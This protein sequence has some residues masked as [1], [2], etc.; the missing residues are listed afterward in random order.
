M[1]KDWTLLDQFRL[2]EGRF[3]SEEGA[4]EGAFQMPFRSSKL[5]IIATHGGHDGWE[6][7]SVSLKNR[8]PN[9]EEMS[10]VKNHFWDPHEAVFQYHPPASEYVNNHP[11]CLHLWRPVDQQMPI[12][13]SLAVGFKELT[14]KDFGYA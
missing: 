10:F 12:P 6:H 7:V 1:K 11:Y 5:M 9:W 13:P 14:P 8:C 2:M 4:H 3:K